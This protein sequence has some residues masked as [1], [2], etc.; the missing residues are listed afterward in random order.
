MRNVVFPALGR[1]VSALGFCCASLGSQVSELQGRRALDAAFERGVSWYDVAPPYGYGEAE[2]ILGK[3]LAGRRDRATICTKVGI[4]RPTV[5]PIV[6]MIRPLARFAAR[7]VPEVWERI[8]LI[9]T[10]PNR[11]PLRA[12]MIEASLVESLRRLR[13]DYVDVLALHDPSPRDCTDEAVLRV[14]RRVVEK[15]YVRQVSIAGRPD[16]ILAGAGASTVF[17]AAQFPENMFDQAADG[18]RAALPPEIQPFFITHCVF[19]KGALERL[20]HLLTTKG[21]Q[22]ASLASQLGYNPPTIAADLLLDYAF[23]KNPAGVVLL[24]MFSLAHIELNCGRASRAPRAD[25]GPFVQKFI[26]TPR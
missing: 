26:L 5:P 2:F 16:A 19:G 10:A 4:P 22:L 15:G 21:G 9:E 12:D 14:L 24:S 11:E 23:A 8:G 17:S 18:L 7:I 1:E 3:A 25:V 13:T 6:S 20:A